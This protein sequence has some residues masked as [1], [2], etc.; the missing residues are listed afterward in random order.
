MEANRSFQFKEI[1]N[2]KFLD[3]KAQKKT[4]AFKKFCNMELS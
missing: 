4:I 2:L 1:T 3:V